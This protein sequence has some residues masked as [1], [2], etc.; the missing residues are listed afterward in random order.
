MK[1][2]SCDYLAS[3]T[4]LQVGVEMSNHMPAPFPGRSPTRIA[5]SYRSLMSHNAPR[6]SYL[7]KPCAKVVYQFA[8]LHRELPPTLWEGWIAEF[9]RTHSRIAYYS[10]AEG[11]SWHPTLFSLYHYWDAVSPDLAYFLSSMHMKRLGGL[12]VYSPLRQL[13]AERVQAWLDWVRN[14]TTWPLPPK[15][16]RITLEESGADAEEGM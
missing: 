2:F 10:S 16:L 7:G 15:K 1:Q 3:R 14:Q 6:L 13:R 4:H 8:E 11:M 12:W 9:D 5:W